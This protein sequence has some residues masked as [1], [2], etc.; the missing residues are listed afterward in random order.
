MHLLT[1]NLSLWMYIYYI[2]KSASLPANKIFTSNPL[3][4]LAQNVY[5]A[6]TKT[7]TME[8]F[9]YLQACLHRAEGGHHCESFVNK[10]RQFRLCIF[11]SLQQ[12]R[13][14]MQG[15]LLWSLCLKALALSTQ[16]QHPHPT[17]AHCKSSHMLCKS[18]SKCGGSRY[19]CSEC[20]TLMIFGGG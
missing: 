4:A 19:P 10:Q 5:S 12:R 9:P 17:S 16:S 15:I 1:A 18:A 2:Y 3:H 11:I 6:Y 8:Q 20:R 7:L 14:Q 13:Q